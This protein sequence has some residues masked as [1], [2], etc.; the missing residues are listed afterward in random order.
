VRTGTFAV[1]ELYSRR[2]APGRASEASR[3]DAPGWAADG[4]IGSFDPV[5]VVDEEAR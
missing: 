4:G 2:Q 5:P 3:I 1:S